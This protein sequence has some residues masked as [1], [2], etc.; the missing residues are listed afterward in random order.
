MGF[1][2][3]TFS[4]TGGTERVAEILAREIAG[5][6]VS[7]NILDKRTET[8]KIEFSKDD[9][10]MIA[11]PAFGGR[12]PAAAADRLKNFA[13]N[14]AKAIIVA[15]YGNRAYDDTLIE[16]KDIAK[17]I[18]FKVIAGISAVSEH[19]ILREFGHGR[20][21][22]DDEKI[23]KD[24]AQKIKKRLDT[25]KEVLS[26]VPGNR[27]YRVYNPVPIGI[28]VNEDC[29]GC[30]ICA[31]ECP[32]QII[33]K[34]N[35]SAAV[36]ENCISC[37]RCIAVCPSKARYADLEKTAFLREKIRSACEQRKDCELF[38]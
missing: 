14:G 6:Y 2:K 7:V 11:V 1:Y 8:Q 5:E 37:M 3:I 26:W 24:M 19:S 31:R 32:M 30:G 28:F 20:P 18:G 34:Q 4:P 23:L 9:I 25:G 21:D 33:D 27:P 22:N 36:H 12:V 38:L 17:E 10:C 13:G 35:L 15:V 29:T 16:L